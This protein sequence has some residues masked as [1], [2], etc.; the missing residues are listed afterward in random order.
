M[1]VARD[2]REDDR[3]CRGEAFAKWSLLIHN[4]T[5]A[6]TTINIRSVAAQRASPLRSDMH[7]PRSL[8]PIEA[9]FVSRP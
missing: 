9:L 4:V 7:R 1:I 5:T 6:S 8:T 2:D 3:H